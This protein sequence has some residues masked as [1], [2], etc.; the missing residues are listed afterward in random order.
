MS[1]KKNKA[2]KVPKVVG[3]GLISLDIVM[4]PSPP[5][6][7]RL[8]AGGTCGNVLAILAYFGWD[9]YPVARLGAD[10][11][12]NRVRRDLKRWGVHCDYLKLPP[13]TATPVIRERINADGSH[14]FSV[15]CSECGHWYPSYR[16]VTQKAIEPVLDNLCDADVFFFDRAS[17]GAIMIAEACREA[18]ACIVFEPS[19]VGNPNQFRKAVGVADIVKYSCERMSSLPEIGEI[20]KPLIEIVTFGEDG[21][22]LRSQLPGSGRGWHKIPAFPVPKV[23]DSAGAGDW[24]TATVIDLLRR[25]GLESL[26]S[27][28]FSSLLDII[29]YGQAASAW[30]CAYES[31]RGGMYEIDRP[32]LMGILD[33]IVSGSVDEGEV[34]GKQAPSRQRVAASTVCVSCGNPTGSPKRTSKTAKSAKISSRTR[35]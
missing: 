26:S 35:R 5:N 16:P 18:G 21:I 8:Y 2:S 28:K 12:T 31:A 1:I 32:E 22:Q 17:A 25:Q 3:T 4:G 15:T 29:N 11:L 27:L 20:P 30:N 33:A 23:R 6:A 10:E 7:L 34:Y 9:A 13:R 19:S 14:K 24:M